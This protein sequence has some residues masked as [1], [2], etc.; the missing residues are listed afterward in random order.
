MHLAKQGGVGMT[1]I[2][3]C[4][5]SLCCQASSWHCSPA[6]SSIPTVSLHS[7]T[8]SLLKT[9]LV[10]SSGSC[11]LGEGSISLENECSQKTRNWLGGGLGEGKM[12]EEPPPLLSTPSH[13]FLCLLSQSQPIS[14]PPAY[15]PGGFPIKQYC[16][17]I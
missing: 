17:L 4:T 7:E 11:V 5:S 6:T 16:N 3:T 12:T 9:Q 2:L 1:P 8:Q 15:E 14:P 13:D 10:Q